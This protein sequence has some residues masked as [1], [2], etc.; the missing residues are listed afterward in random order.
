MKKIFKAH[1]LMIFEFLKPTLLVL[2]FPLIKGLVQYFTERN[3]EGVVGLFVIVVCAILT[4]AV[5]RWRSY[6]LICNERDQ[7]ITIKYGVLF[8]RVAK[9]DVYKLSSVQTTQNPIDFL[10][11]AVTYKINTEA[12]NHNRTDFEFK[13]SVK[14]SK[15]VSAM[16][17]GKG[18]P[19]AVKYSALKVA[20]L[21]A[22][23]S[24]A[25]TGMLVA[26]PLINR[27]GNLLGIGLS[28]M[29]LN[30]INN[31]SGKIETYFPPI[32]NTVTLVILIAYFISFVYSFFK[33]I[34]FK[35]FLEDKKLEVR[36]GIIVR[37]RTSFR[38]S[39]IN[40]IKVE[41]TLL[42]RLLKRYALKV[43]VG[44]YGDSKS[45]SEVIIPLGANK[46][47]KNKL[48]KYFPFF[49]PTEKG[50]KPAQTRLTQS[51]YLFLPAIY[52]LATI[53]LSVWFALRFGDL[54]RFV[55]FL[56]FVVCVT[57]FCY[58]YM[59]LFEFYKSKIS[60]G[61]NIF[62]RS[63]RGLRTYE[64]Y[65]PKENVGEIRIIRFLPDLWYKTCRVRV[66]VRS[67]RADNIRVRHLD[68]DTVKR[69]VYKCFQIE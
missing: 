24:S 42:M 51:R 58:A 22:T 35:L 37:T 46:E 38:K 13:L 67:E 29:L 64:L 57:I 21:A 15:A 60:F 11:R 59:G 43:S 50:I 20:I 36:S 14:N 23:T 44:G 39:A 17:Y 26:A 66:L 33:Y 18:Q 49:V 30:E 5:L 16:L 62:A 65:C 12:G 2:F 27:A 47:I 52:L 34:N 61:D 4:V 55:F 25:F 41:Q 10:C 54:T 40:N 28:D 48:S 8:K 56:T 3:L 69:E 45:E 9:I 53:L 1:P 68:Y 6:K 7:V 63:N 19:K 32:V 31:I